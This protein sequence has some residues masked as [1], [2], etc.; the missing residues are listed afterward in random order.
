MSTPPARHPPLPLHTLDHSLCL[1]ILLH[2]SSPEVRKESTGMPIKHGKG[3]VPHS[4]GLDVQ[5]MQVSW[6]GLCLHFLLRFR[7]G[8]VQTPQPATGKSGFVH[9][10]TYLLK[11][12]EGQPSLGR[13]EKGQGRKHCFQSWHSVLK[14]AEFPQVHTHGRYSTL[15]TSA[16]SNR[17]L[18]EKSRI[19]RNGQVLR[20][21]FS[22][23]WVLG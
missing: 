20:S 16:S 17:G 21:L 22:A 23:C 4:L 7:I 2:A 9:K 5:D 10:S 12:T 13:P 11:G 1:P 6:S 8:Q 15:D 19:N 18:K 14:C 3:V